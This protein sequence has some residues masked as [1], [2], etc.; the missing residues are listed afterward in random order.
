MKIAHIA[1]HTGNFGDLLSARGLYSILDKRLQSYELNKIEIRDYYLNGQKPG[2]FAK[3]VAYLLD[4]NDKVIIGGGGFLTPYQGYR[5]NPSKGLISFG[6]ELL[7]S[8]DAQRIAI[9]SMGYEGDIQDIPTSVLAKQVDFLKNIASKG[10]S[11]SLRRDPGTM[12]LKKLGLVDDDLIFDDFGFH[13]SP[14]NM[15]KKREIVICPSGGRG[16]EGWEDNAEMLQIF[17]FTIKQAIAQNFV[18]NL[19]L[20]TLFDLKIAGILTEQF[21]SVSERLKINIIYA[22][23]SSCNVHE[24][25]SVYGRSLGVISGRYHGVAAGITQN[26]LVASYRCSK[27]ANF[28]SKYYGG[29]EINTKSDVLEFLGKAL[30][31]QAIWIGRVDCV[32]DKFSE[33]IDL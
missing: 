16:G 21:K 25:L 9:V 8:A 6:D 4:S 3:D 28:A 14:L 27:K 17:S 5:A 12:L 13:C 20:H 22:G 7:D 11:V 18:V 32:S 19:V 29:L 33:F 1:A 30:C 24:I 31:G 2:D 15:A 10:V 26:A 23:N